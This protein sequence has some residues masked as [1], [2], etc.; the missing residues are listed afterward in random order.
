LSSKLLVTQKG[1]FP[2]YFY[3]PRTLSG[4]AASVIFGGGRSFRRDSLACIG[5]LKPPLHILGEENIPQAGPCLIT[6]NHY[7]RPGFDAWWMAL[8]LA[9]VVP[10]EIHFVMTGELTFPGKWYAPFGMFGSR[11]LLKWL[12]HLYGFTAMPPMPPRPRDVAARA[13][14]VREALA[15]VCHNPRAMIGLAPEGGDQPDGML[16]W[17]PAGA[18]RFVSLLAAYGLRI[19]PV[20]IYEQDGAFCLHFGPAYDLRPRLDLPS[21][22]RDRA[23]AGAVMCQIA[24]L[25]PAA[26]RGTFAV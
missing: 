18:G 24:V 21:D 10:I 26:L 23:V 8:A 7:F 25:L 15:F 6:F 17:P 9:A 4:L 11:L 19:A 5:R 16:N 20:G 12:A 13:C 14:A 22:E 1:N 3:P 2:I